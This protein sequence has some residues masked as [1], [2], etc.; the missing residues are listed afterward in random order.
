MECIGARNFTA[1]AVFSF[2]AGTSRRRTLRT[3]RQGGLSNKRCHLYRVRASSAGTDSCVA[4]KEEFADEEDYI[5]AGGSELVYV[6]MQQNKDME[7]QSKLADKVS[8]S[9]Y[10]LTGT[11]PDL[12]LKL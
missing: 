7:Q 9:L 10:L 3:Y 1:M 11:L 6:Q 8:F 12:K 5:K 2:S 4:I